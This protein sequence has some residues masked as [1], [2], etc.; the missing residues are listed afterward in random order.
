[1]IGKRS[2]GLA[3]LVAAAATM[4]IAF[5]ASSASATEVKTA[6]VKMRATLEKQSDQVEPH[7]KLLPKNAY[8]KFFLSCQKSEA[9]FTVPDGTAQPTGMKQNTNRGQKEGASEVGEGE[10]VGTFSQSPGSVSMQIQEQNKAAGF[11]GPSFEECTVREGIEKEPHKQGTAV[12]QATITTTTKW[13]LAANSQ[14]AVGKK[15]SISVAQLA[16]GVPQAG[17]VFTIKTLTEPKVELCKIAIGEE[18]QTVVMGTYNKVSHVGLFDG[19]VKFT[20]E[21]KVAGGCAAVEVEGK[22]LSPA[23]FEAQYLIKPVEPGK[24]EFEILP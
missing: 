3:L 13:M 11:E 19:Q 18:Q 15:E 22:P 1:M 12:A 7:A 9:E 21:P 14:L 6:N 4:A 23:Q 8:S 16:I 24:G 10:H 20:T 2:I 17:A 5:A